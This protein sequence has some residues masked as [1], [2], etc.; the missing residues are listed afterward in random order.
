MSYDLGFGWLTSAE[1]WGRRLL[2]AL[3]TMR[4]WLACNDAGL[5]EQSAQIAERS[6]RMS[7]RWANKILDARQ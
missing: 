5:A 7:A 3:E 6:A 2:E 4:F 1:W